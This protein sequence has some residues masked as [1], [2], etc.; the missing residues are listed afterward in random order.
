M[1]KDRRLGKGGLAV[2]WP[3][4]KHQGKE[5]WLAQP[6]ASE[7][8][9][10]KGARVQPWGEVA[11]HGA[12]RNSILQHFRVGSVRGPQRWRPILKSHSEGVGTEGMC[13][14]DA[15]F[16]LHFPGNVLLCSQ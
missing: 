6:E 8:T 14:D 4:K 3:E 12:H 13:R 15:T 1:G 7:G 2:G 16:S 10:Q 9:G 5:A 11:S